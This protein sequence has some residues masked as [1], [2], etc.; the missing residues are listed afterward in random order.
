[1]IYMMVIRIRQVNPAAP[2]RRFAAG[3]SMAAQRRILGLIASARFHSA[4]ARR[5]DR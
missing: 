2:V 1:M 3:L 5:K 4:A